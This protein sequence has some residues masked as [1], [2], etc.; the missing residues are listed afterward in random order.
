MTTRRQFLSQTGMAGLGAALY[1]CYGAPLAAA[2]HLADPPTIEAPSLSNLKAE[3]QSPARTYR[4]HTRWWW[5]G[6]AVTKGGIEWQ[7][8]QMHAQ[9]MGGVEIMT[10][11]QMYTKGNI[12]Y[13][14]PQFLDMVG[15]AIEQARILDMEVSL[16]FGAGWK[17]GGSWVPPTQRSKVLA[18]ASLDLQGP[19]A[20]DRELPSYVVPQHSQ[21]LARTFESDAPD[22]N[23][24]VAVVAGRISGDELDADTLVD[25]TDQV[26][27]NHLKWSIPAGN[28]RVMVFRLKYTGE[29]N[30]TTENLPQRQW[31]V[32]HFSKP[33]M[34]QY[35]DYL[36]GIFYGAFGAEFG[37]TLDTLF[38][39]SY[40]IMVLPNTIHWS[41]AALEQ[42][43]SYKGYDLRRF[44]PAIWWNI[45]DLTPRI[46]YDVN[47]FLSWLALDAFLGPFVDWC[48]AHHTSARIQAYYRDTCELIQ[49]AGLA[50][51]PEMELTTEGFE[52]IADPR[53]AV[54]AGAHLYGRPIVSA[55]A[56][57][58]IHIERYRT[59]LQDM[60]IATDAFL[61][62]GVT[63]FY[64]H[65]YLYSPEMHVAP[66]R[67]VPW[68]NRISHWNTWWKYYGHL[69]SYISRCC[70]M[71]RQGEFVGDVLLYSPQATV[72]TENVLFGNER[73]IMPYGDLG[74]TLVANGYDFD[75]VN[76]DVLQNRAKVNDG[77]VHAGNLAYR[78]L[79]LPST[80]AVPVKTMEFMRRF[81]VHGGILIALGELPAT[82]VGLN[83]HAEDDARVSAIAK[84][85]FGA[86][87]AGKAHPGGGQ[88][89]HIADYKLPDFATAART[90]VPT[91]HP[92]PPL[93]PLTGPRQTLIEALRSHLQPDFALS[94]DR[95]SQG[96]TFLHRRLG[97]V[98]IYFVTNLQSADIRETVKFRVNGKVPEQWNP[99]TGEVHP[100]LFWQPQASSTHVALRLPAYGSVCLIFKPG[101]I[102]SY[103]SNTNLDEVLEVGPHEIRGISAQNGKVQA[104]V[105]GHGGSWQAE[106]EISDLP[107]SY[108]I[109]G[110]WNLTLESD[111]FP[112]IEK[113]LA[114]LESWTED[115]VT[116]HFSGTG[117][118]DLV[119][120]LPAKYIHDEIELSLDL[121]EVGNVAE[122]IANG[123]HLGVAWMTP[124]RL[125]TQ[126]A[127]RAGANHLTI[128][129]TNTLINYVAGLK[130]LPE[131]PSNLV[132]HYGE[133]NP[134]YPLGAREWESREKGFS[135]LPPSGLIG[136]VAIKTRRKVVLSATT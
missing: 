118:Y 50:P 47:D 72:W 75:P 82:S 69:T 90:V 71:L 5:P 21:Y 24:I 60:K 66:S 49:A 16:S 126:N 23:Q 134:D 38:C 30:A 85:L 56:Y 6:N 107:E 41:N 13:L 102:G 99:M 112:R 54:A 10:P 58:F 81:V 113:S 46:R 18:Q 4:Q 45:G 123:N 74:K 37:K 27:G 76:D 98:D 116:Q 8:R 135:P 106:A 65:G 91:P 86:D 1:E 83:N 35:C 52:V 68:A 51:R 104:T 25:L 44:L 130:Q 109:G 34:R 59:T 15:Y 63:Q 42:F 127:L 19:G 111:Q 119:F 26:K 117:R 32:D 40:E 20:F 89:Y 88:T 48:E 100:V 136:P 39:D 3:W 7:L 96:L 101:S 110:T 103:V 108:T 62:D 95:Q 129:V 79:I 17:F 125:S 124:Y 67:D 105:I 87:G 12:P 73:R 133:T 80:K 97:E 43:R 70:V 61:R 14:S 31:V 120:E 28:W 114:K 64:N 122:V 53:K 77:R 57:T 92:Y 2:E 78:F 9:G 33:A 94:G 55:E 131:V 115:P 121:G 29:Q 93:P 22:E 128:L 132:A 84:E 36:G 11:W